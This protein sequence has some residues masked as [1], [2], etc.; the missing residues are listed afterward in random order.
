MSKFEKLQ[1][2]IG[3][4]SRLT[5]GGVLFV[6]GYLKVDKLEVSQMAVRSYELLPIPIANFL[7]QTLPFFEVVVGLL[8]ILGAATR[9]VAALGGFTMFIFIIA[10]AQAWARGLN[11]DCGCFGGGGTV[12][13]GQTRY[14]QEILR[15]AGLVALALFL[16][17]YPITKFSI[18]KTPKQSNAGDT[19]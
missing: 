14:L 4:L 9:A 12:D 10:I 5:L 8:L 1:P 6:A 2:W 11:I 13:P 15:D 19:E 17:R 16:V 7:G 18:D 3:L